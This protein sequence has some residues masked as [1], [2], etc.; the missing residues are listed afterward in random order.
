[1]TPMTITVQST[2]SDTKQKMDSPKETE[3]QQQQHMHNND[4]A[5]HECIYEWPEF[6]SVV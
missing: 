3:H 5:E 1:M 4:K 2:H 6:V